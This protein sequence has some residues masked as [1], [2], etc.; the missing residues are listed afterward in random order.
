[1]RVTARDPTVLDLAGND[2]LELA[3][4]PAVAAAVAAAAAREGTSASASPHITGWK[5]PHER[6]VRALCGWHGYAHG[7]LWSSGY[8]A[9]TAVLGVL[10]R[11]GDLVLA[12]RLI[13]HSM[14]AGLM[15]GEAR[16]QR[17]PHLD[18]DRLE[19][20]LGSRP[21]CTFVVT[22]S[23][24]SM[25]GDYPDLAR[26]AEMKRRHGFCWI[27][28]EA[29]ALGWYGPGGSGLARAAG[30][31]EHVDILVGTLGKTLASGGAYTLF[32]D[33]SVREHLVNTAGE[34]I[35]STA[36]PPA[37]AAGAE[38]ALAR[39]RE[40]SDGQP[41]WHA[42]SRSFREALRAD[43]WTVQEGDSPIVPVRL[44][45]ED[46]ALDLAAFLRASGILAAAV[47]PPTVPAGTSR[48]RFS[49]KRG[50]GAAG[51]ARVMDAMRAWRRGLRP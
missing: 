32:R 29:H 40:L 13:H 41:H 30:V 27:L 17:Y 51:Q 39:V 8:A 25:D 3:H 26:L 2:Y 9:N 42:A 16:L 10:P 44:D 12:D 34:F 31:E 6:L 48:L 45:D 33:E 4:D 14:I 15:R 5:E 43:G 20:L 46:K 28:D 21:G 11:R 35:Y 18:L 36:I 38:A 1:V 49:L 19:S 47:R 50:F 37:N 24:F 23:V 7:L 22:E